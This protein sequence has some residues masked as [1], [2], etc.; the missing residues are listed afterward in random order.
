MVVVTSW[1]VLISTGGAHDTLLTLVTIRR[2]AD[3]VLEARSLIE[4]LEKAVCM[5]TEVEY[6]PPF[7][8]IG[9]TGTNS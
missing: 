9:S 4:A 2:L 7:L 1:S 8:L 6:Q 3:V 5:R